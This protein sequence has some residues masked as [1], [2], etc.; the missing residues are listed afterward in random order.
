MPGPRSLATLLVAL[1]LAATAALGA[2]PRGG[3]P[4]ARVAL[5]FLLPLGVGALATLRVRPARRRS[6]PAEVAVPSV[7]YL[8]FVLV[9]LAV[10]AAPVAL[11]ALAGAFTLATGAPAL[12]TARAVAVL[13]GLAAIGFVWTVGWEWGLR[14][15]LYGPWAAAGRPRRAFV[16]S[17]AAG[18][19]LSLPAIAPGFAIA[20]PDYFLAALAAAALREAIAVRLYRRAGILLSGAFRGWPPDSRPWSPPTGSPSGGQRRSTPPRRPPSSCCARPAPP[21]PPCSPGPSS[22]GSTVATPA[23]ASSRER[24]PAASRSDDLPLARQAAGEG[25]QGDRPEGE[26]Q[27]LGPQVAERLL[28]PEDLEEALERPGVEG[29]QAELLQRHRHQ[30]AREHRAAER[31]DRQDHQVRHGRPAACASGRAPPARGRTP[32]RPAPSA[33]PSSGSRR[34]GRAARGRRR[35][36]PRRTSTTSWTKPS[37]AR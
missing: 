18:T 20:E 30:E 16:A 26:D 21:P 23:A 37:E 33:P 10:D 24:T 25:H 7:R 36:T 1:G 14:A 34:G 19:A 12:S 8:P 22:P 2:V 28:A 13:L 32:S 35:P 3:E 5:L 27:H 29:D 17:V 31:R 6:F 11:G 9:L 15:R 4:W